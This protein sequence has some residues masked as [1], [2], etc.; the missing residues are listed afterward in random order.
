M[1]DCCAPVRELSLMRGLAAFGCVFVNHCRRQ[2]RP[3]TPPA[4]AVVAPVDAGSSATTSAVSL[5]L[6]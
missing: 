4:P 2:S 1:R 5:I 6:P 3:G